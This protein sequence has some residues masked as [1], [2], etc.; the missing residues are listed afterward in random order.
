MPVPGTYLPNIP[1]PTDQLSVSQGD[2]LT[3]FQSL[4]AWIDI[5]HVDYANANAGM[6]NKVQFP[7][8]GAAPQPINPGGGIVG[9]YSQTSSYTS[10]PEICVQKQTSGVHYE[11]TSAGYSAG[12]NTAPGWAM[13]PSGILIKWGLGTAIASAL[14]VTL[15]A[16]GQP[17]YSAVYTAFATPR[18]SSQ[19]VAFTS[20]T[21]TAT[22]TFAS[23]TATGQMTF[24]VIG[25]ANSN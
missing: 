15:N 9:M 20:F 18:S 1:Q 2:L 24:F 10:Q 5:D 23:S 21:G 25:L 17:T 4:Q 19:T 12:T 14:A 16:A 3:N 8:R 22:A 13:L 6:H 7:T 11:F